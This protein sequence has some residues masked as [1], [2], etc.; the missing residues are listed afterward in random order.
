[1]FS[2]IF[3]ISVPQHKEHFRFI[4]YSDQDQDLSTKCFKS[5]LKPALQPKLSSCPLFTAGSGVIK[6]TFL[7]CAMKPG[8]VAKP[9]SNP[10]RSTSCQ[11]S[12]EWKSPCTVGYVG[13]L[14]ISSDIL[15][16]LA[17]SLRTPGLQP[18]TQA[19]HQPLPSEGP[20]SGS[21]SHM[22]RLG[23]G[24]PQTGMATGSR[25]LYQ[26]FLPCWLLL[27]TIL[28]QNLGTHFITHKSFSRWKRG[29]T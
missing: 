24:R 19:L 21:P 16:C 27:Q 20:V 28:S 10:G 23:A 1:M 13:S 6:E 25:M 8:M 9:L 15:G 4:E 17:T 2:L 11:G 7:N 22:G 18:A 3:F 5:L 12:E 26:T 14:L 29:T